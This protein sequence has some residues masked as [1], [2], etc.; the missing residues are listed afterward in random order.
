MKGGL[1]S[2]AVDLRGATCVETSRWT[3]AVLS[4]VSH[5]ENGSSSLSLG[6]RAPL[7]GTAHG[8]SPPSN[9]VS[10]GGGGGGGD[11]RAQDKPQALGTQVG[12]EDSWLLGGD[13]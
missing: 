13:Q 11:S 7:E 8:V 10:R 2:T 3:P 1:Q 5:R 12:G 9:A 6:S 4:S